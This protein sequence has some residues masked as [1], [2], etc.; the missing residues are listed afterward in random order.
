ATDTAVGSARAGNV[1][2]GGDWADDRLIPDILKAFSVGETAIVR[3]P[4]A[5]RPWQHVLEP[6]SGYLRLAEA[7]YKTGQDA[8][9]PWNFGPFDE[10]ARPV[11]WITEQMSAMWGEGARWEI[12]NDSKQP[13]EAT[14]LKLDISR[15]RA[16]L[17]WSPTWTLQQTLHRIVQWQRGWL[18]HSDTR[19]LCLDEITAF[20][21]SRKDD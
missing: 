11:S 2:G 16:F 4:N 1:I 3:N 7:L 5:I 21:A 6:L 15:A 17:N 19:Q 14:Y 20:C 8:A 10:G 18:N 12:L 13:H 9:R